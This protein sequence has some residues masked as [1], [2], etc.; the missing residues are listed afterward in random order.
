MNMRNMLAAT[1]TSVALGLTGCS[2]APEMTAEDLKGMPISQSVH[3]DG[4]ALTMLGP[5]QYAA[6]AT[7]SVTGKATLGQFAIL[8]NGGNDIKHIVDADGTTAGP[9]TLDLSRVPSGGKSTF[10]GVGI[11]NTGQVAPCKPITLAKS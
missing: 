7:F 11:T 5:D 8:G 6:R 4:V 3:C 1:G 10:Q 9:I 2:G